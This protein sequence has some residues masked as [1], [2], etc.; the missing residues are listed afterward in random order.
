MSLERAEPAESGRFPG[1]FQHA[2]ES[3]PACGRPFPGSPQSQLREKAIDYH[4]ENSHGPE[5][6]GLSPIGERRTR[7][8]SRV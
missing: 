3:C 6:F 4:L 8:P 7:R 5:D 1:G 2:L